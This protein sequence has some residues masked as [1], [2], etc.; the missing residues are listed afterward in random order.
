METTH[1]R[2]TPHLVYR[3]ARHMSPSVRSHLPQDAA[4]LGSHVIEFRVR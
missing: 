2:G 3:D 1:E 4:K